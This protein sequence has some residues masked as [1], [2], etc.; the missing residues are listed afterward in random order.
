M[1]PGA[2]SLFKCCPRSLREMME[3]VSNANGND[4]DDDDESTPLFEANILTALE[5]FMYWKEKDAAKSLSLKQQVDKARQSL[6]QVFNME[7]GRW[8]AAY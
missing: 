5:M 8:C 4:D 3:N 6:R 7:R 2:L 1:I